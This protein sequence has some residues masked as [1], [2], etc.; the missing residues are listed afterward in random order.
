M[1]QDFTKCRK[2][3]ASMKKKNAPQGQIL[4]PFTTV[5][6]SRTPL[7]VRD[8]SFIKTSLGINNRPVDGRSSETTW[9]NNE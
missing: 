6:N 3:F 5:V 9:V 8:H 1:S 4:I 7:M 2:S